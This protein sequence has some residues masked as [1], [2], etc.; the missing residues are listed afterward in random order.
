V[1][2]VRDVDKGVSGRGFTVSSRQFTEREGLNAETRRTQRGAEKR[3]GAGNGK[4]TRHGKRAPEACEERITVCVRGVY[5]TEGQEG[6]TKGQNR[7]R[8][9]ELAAGFSTGARRADGVNMEGKI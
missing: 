9:L 2:F 1:D 4:W 3:A 6:K 7:D 5:G 8:V